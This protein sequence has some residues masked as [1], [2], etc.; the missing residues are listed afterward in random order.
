MIRKRRPQLT[1]GIKGVPALTRARQDPTDRNRR[2]QAGR[3]GLTVE[4]L[5]ELG[6]ACAICGFTGPLVV[7]HDHE[8]AGRHGHDPA[9][10]CWVCVRGKL[11]DYC[12]TGLGKFGDDPERLRRAADFLERA[13]IR[14]LTLEGRD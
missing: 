12:N 3:H 11:C 7:D 4:Q 6:D 13:L 1:T 2:E 8:A 5:D 10:G 14:T 9:R